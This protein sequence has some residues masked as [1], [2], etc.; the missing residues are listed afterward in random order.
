MNRKNC[1]NCDKEIVE[2]NFIVHVAYC[3]RYMVRCGKCEEVFKKSEL[4]EHEE[5]FHIKIQCKFCMKLIEKV[6]EK[7]HAEIC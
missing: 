5:E 4:K 3:E 1:P 7:V 2:S 6:E